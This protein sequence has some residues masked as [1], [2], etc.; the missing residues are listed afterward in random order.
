MSSNFS[1]VHGYFVAL[2]DLAVE[3]EFALEA[4]VFAEAEVALSSELFVV[5][6]LLADA[7][8]FAGFCVPPPEFVADARAAPNCATTSP[9]AEGAF[10]P[11]EEEFAA[12]DFCAEDLAASEDFAALVAVGNWIVMGDGRVRPPGSPAMSCGIACSH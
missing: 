4:V 5:V 6:T 7:D 12:P 10:V 9:V 1:A 11:C 8:P 3:S 2:L